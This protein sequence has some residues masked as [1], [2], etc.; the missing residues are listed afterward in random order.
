[1]GQAAEFAAGPWI[2]RQIPQFSLPAA[3][4]GDNVTK[5]YNPFSPRVAAGQEKSISH[6]RGETDMIC[7]LTAD[8]W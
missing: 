5:W 7:D 6:D 1:M 3:G 4:A 8:H 2:V